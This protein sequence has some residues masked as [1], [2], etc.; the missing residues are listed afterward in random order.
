LHQQGKP[1]S[2][3][4]MERKRV[5]IYVGIDVA[6]ETLQ[7]CV[8]GAGKIQKEFANK[9]SGHKQLTTWLKQYS[10][11]GVFVGMEATGSYGEAVC[12]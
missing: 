2:N 9:A 12:E 8:L 5:M 11:E 6:K 1:K 7:V 4:N 3:E 10:D